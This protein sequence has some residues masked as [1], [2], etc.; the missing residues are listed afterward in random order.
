M[1]SRGWNRFDLAGLTS[2][3]LLRVMAGVERAAAELRAAGAT[4]AMDV[5]EKRTDLPRRPEL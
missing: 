2:R 5:Y 1:Y 3:N 4:P